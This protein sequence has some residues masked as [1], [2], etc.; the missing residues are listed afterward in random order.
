MFGCWRKLISCSYW[1]C[2][3]GIWL[4]VDE[5][6]WDPLVGW[7]EMFISAWLALIKDLLFVEVGMTMFFIA[8]INRVDNSITKY[9][10]PR[11]ILGVVWTTF[12][13]EFWYVC[14]IHQNR[15]VFNN[16]KGFVLT[17]FLSKKRINVINGWERVYE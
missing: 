10:H 8:E 6:S 5:A 17:I 12:M 14:S 11:N 2:D 16:S 7:V 3:I 15:G 9:A 4:L 13:L 1:A